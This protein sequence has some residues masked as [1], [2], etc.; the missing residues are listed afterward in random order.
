M[1]SW[2]EM[3]HGS[4]AWDLHSQSFEMLSQILNPSVGDELP[5]NIPPLLPNTTVFHISCITDE[6]LLASMRWLSPS[7]RDVRIR[8]GK[9]VS[10]VAVCIAMQRM[11]SLYLCLESVLIEYGGI[12]LLNPPELRLIALE[13]S[14]LLITPTLKA[15]CLPY[16]FT[17][18]GSIGWEQLSGLPELGELAFF[19]RCHYTTPAITYEQAQLFS[20]TCGQGF[21]CF[22]ALHTLRLS[23]D[24]CSWE[25]LIA[26]TAVSNGLSR[27]RVLSL[28][29]AKQSSNEHVPATIQYLAQHAP[30]LQDFTIRTA[31]IAENLRMD[32]RGVVTIPSLKHF[33]LV[34]GD[35]G[36]LIRWDRPLAP[37]VF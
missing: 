30:M 35:G 24:D 5:I 12:H 18:I 26:A 23:Q 3:A 27:I 2:D 11:T 36:K 17:P 15:V 34:D 1:V 22:P 20:R 13:I 4:I 29:T 14:N 9:R 10:S 19:Y 8:I 25:P 7:V 32:T 31:V 33:A 16:D 6:G 37:A 21:V 28:N